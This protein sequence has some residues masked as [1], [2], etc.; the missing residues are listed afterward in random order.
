MTEKI[1]PEVL[2]TNDSTWTEETNLFYTLNLYDPS[3]HFVPQFVLLETDSNMFLICRNA[4]FS[5][6]KHLIVVDA[7]QNKGRVLEEATMKELQ[8]HIIL[9]EKGWIKTNE[10]F[11]FNDS[12]EPIQGIRKIIKVYGDAFDP[13]LAQSAKIGKSL[14]MAFFKGLLKN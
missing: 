11:Y 8:S 7:G 1:D 3:H 5:A 13:A 6:H 14:H 12:E 4:D 10:H 9:S 2:S